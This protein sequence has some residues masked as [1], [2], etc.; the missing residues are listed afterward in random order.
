MEREPR[1]QYTIG[2]V[3]RRT[4]LSPDV[5][6]AWERRYGV[7]APSRTQ[8]GDRV[9]SQADVERLLLLSRA[10]TAGHP[11]RSV[12]GLSP[13]ELGA[14]VSEEELLR[15]S[16]ED[17]RGSRASRRGLTEE[18]MAAVMAMDGNRIHS[19][20]TMAVVTLGVT[21]FGE[22]L[23]GVLRQVGELWEDGEICPAHEHLLSGNVQRVLG[24]LLLTIPVPP[25]ARGIVVST[26]R[27]HRHE[28]A[29]LLAAVEAATEG[30]RVTYL[31]P[32]L[33][34]GDIGSAVSATGASAVALSVVRDARQQELAEEVLALRAV[35]PAGFPI[36]LGG[37]GAMANTGALETAGATVLPDLAGLR[38]ALRALAEDR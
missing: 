11:I 22:W 27:G 36:L 29:A 20:L 35:L 24:W 2:A 17:E 4:G 18:C 13:A 38:A 9:Y 31:G 19:V 28:L 37:A 3:A 30:W 1:G 21:G 7:V 12:A 15:E 33:R 16:S 32:D 23:G 5:L 8:G 25:E 6:R 10:V 34:A 14:L 26:P